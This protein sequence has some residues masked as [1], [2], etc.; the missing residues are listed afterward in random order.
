[1]KFVNLVRNPAEN[2]ENAARTPDKTVPAKLDLAEVR[3]EGRKGLWG[4]RHDT[5]ITIMLIDYHNSSAVMPV[6]RIFT[7]VPCFGIGPL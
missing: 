1:M 6:A 5:D 2:D 4:E 3:A 7:F